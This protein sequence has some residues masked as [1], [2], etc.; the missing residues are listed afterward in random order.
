MISLSFSKDNE[1]EWRYVV[2]RENGE[3]VALCRNLFEVQKIYEDAGYLLDMCEVILK[4]PVDIADIVAFRTYYAVMIE[5]TEELI[6]DGARRTTY[7]SKFF[8]IRKIEN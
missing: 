5:D 8:K 3:L 2:H 7:D 6:I 4:Y 1:S